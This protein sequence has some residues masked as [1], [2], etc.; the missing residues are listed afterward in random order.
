[1]AGN[2]PQYAA[3]HIGLFPDLF[4]APTY[5]YHSLP[6]PELAI[7]LDDGWRLHVQLDAAGASYLRKLAATLAVAADVAEQ[8]AALPKAP[9]LSVRGGIR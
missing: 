2:C 3:G 7:E 4:F 5:L 1:M 6:R 8:A 9:A